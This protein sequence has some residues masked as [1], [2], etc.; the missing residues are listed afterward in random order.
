MGR[1]RHDRSISFETA[2]S[3]DLQTYLSSQSSIESPSRPQRDRN[4]NLRYAMI[5]HVLSSAEYARNESRDHPEQEI[6]LKPGAL[7]MQ[8]RKSELV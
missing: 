8:V 1:G 7:V 5:V 3:L 4:I 2:K 6:R